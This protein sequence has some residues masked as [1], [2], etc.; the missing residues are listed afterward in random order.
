MI[1]CTLKGADGLQHRVMVR[2][3]RS[4]NF[5]PR[6]ELEVAVPLAGQEAEA[7]SYFGPLPKFRGVWGV[8]RGG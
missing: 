5:R 7:W 4:E 3:M 1:Y 8:P 6:M 2:V